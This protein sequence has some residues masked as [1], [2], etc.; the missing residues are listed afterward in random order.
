MLQQECV[1]I[2]VSMVDNLRK[3]IFVKDEIEA[4]IVI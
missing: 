4:H 2:A 1:I 3:Y